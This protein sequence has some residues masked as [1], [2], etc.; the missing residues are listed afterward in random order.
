MATRKYIMPATRLD[1]HILN[2]CIAYLKNTFGN[3]TFMPMINIP[4][5]H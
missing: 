2:F 5:K 4:N 3:A 1:Q